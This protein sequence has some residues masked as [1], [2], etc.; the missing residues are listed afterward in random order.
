MNN[1]LPVTQLESDES[2][3]SGKAEEKGG[4]R[5]KGKPRK[6]LEEKKDWSTCCAVGICGERMNQEEF[7]E[8]VWQAV[9]LFEPDASSPAVC[10]V[11]SQQKQASG[12]PALFG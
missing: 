3:S 1:L 4:M 9:R 8:V 5:K 2:D 11:S 7:Q 6:E 10:V 12:S